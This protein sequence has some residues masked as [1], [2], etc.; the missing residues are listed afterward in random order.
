MPETRRRYDSEFREGAVRI[1]RETGK[2]IA[3]VARDLGGSGNDELYGGD[4]TDRLSGG[5][6]ADLV[7]GEAGTADRCGGP[8]LDRSGPGCEK[9]IS[10]P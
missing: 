2:P 7:A 4:G 10:V 3:Q 1:V 9:L 5:D 8:G 6:G